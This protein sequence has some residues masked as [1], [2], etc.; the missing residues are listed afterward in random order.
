MG[1]REKEHKSR[2]QAGQSVPPFSLQKS[3][4]VFPS[5]LTMTLEPWM[6]H[7]DAI[8]VPWRAEHSAS[9]T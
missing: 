4:A 9:L 7:S 2:V 8:D 5:P 3:Q 6:G 1:T